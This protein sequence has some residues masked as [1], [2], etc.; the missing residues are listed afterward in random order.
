MENQIQ[1][2]QTN[3]VE[4][5]A[6]QGT[7]NAVN[8]EQTEVAATVK[9]EIKE[10]ADVG[11]LGEGGKESSSKQDDATNKK[12]ADIRRSYERKL[13]EAEKAKEDA[14][15]AKEVEMVKKLYKSNQWTGEPI[16]DEHDVEE[17]LAMQALADEGKDPLSEYPKLFKQQKKTAAQAAKTEA[18][19][20]KQRQIMAQEN[21]RE[22]QEKYG[23]VNIA[24]LLNDED[25]LKFGKKALE[26][27]PLTQVYEAY[28]PIKTEKE[29]IKAEQ[30]KVAAL[31][32]NSKVAVGSVTSATS[33]VDSEY[34]TP[35]QVRKM[36]KEE[37]R[38][39]Y[40]KIR[41]SQEK[42]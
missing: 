31:A 23:D 36:S 33:P 20:S 9:Q 5:A 42:W 12:F 13:K 38:K 27:I 35:E 30:Q 22:F 1:A 40:E 16:E 18:D 15:K 29:R 8:S 7:D 3:N 19:K 32:L 21:L 26:I 41:K 10:G 6:N 17:L 24:E 2:G 14:L 4:V 25:F 37:I 39:N 28:L 34:F 11:V